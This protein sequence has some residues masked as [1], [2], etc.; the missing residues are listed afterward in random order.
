MA[1][2]E[3]DSVCTF[4]CPDACSLSV[5]VDDGRIVAV[6]GSDAVPYT[7]SV[8]CNKVARDMGD[9]VHG[10]QRL[11]HPL[12]RI[13]PKGSGQ[14]ARI[15][16]DTALDEIHQRVSDIVSRWG[17]QAVMP[18]NYAGPHGFLAGDSMSS[19]FFNRL[20]A[21]QL[22]RR[23]L[24]GG[25][26]SEAW[27]GTYGAVPGCPPEF[28]EHAKLNVVWG[29]NATVANLHLV[30]S[31]SHARRKG[32]RLVVVD[33]LRTKIAEQA[34]LHLQLLPGTDILLAWSVA[35]ELER[36]GALDDDFIAANVLGFEEFMALARA[37][38]AAR[39]AAACGLPES[40][41][42]TFAQWLAAADPLVLTPGNGLERGRNGGSGIRAAIALPAL[43]GKL[44]KGSGIVLAAGNAFPKTPAKLQRP[45]LI[46]AGTR[47]LN[48]N[49]IGRHLAED[50]LDPPLRALFI[51][52][53]NPIVVHP[54]QN[55]MRRGLA[56][57]DL[58]AVGIDVTMTESMAHCDVV[59]PAATHFEYAELYPSYGHHWL[60]R[61]E[62]VIP[63]VGESLPNTEIFRRLA[64]RFGFV[65]PCFTATDEELI[66]DA[67][68]PA[69][70]RLAGVRP[71]RISTKQALPMTGPDGRPLVLYD[72]IF[73][74]TPSGKIELKSATLAERWGAAALLPGWRPLPNPPPLAGEGRVGGPLMLIS[75]ASDKRISSTLG[76]LAGS[77]QAPPLLMNPQDAA[78]R[79]L[80]D[81]AEVR[82]WNDRGEVILRLDVTDKVPPGVVASEK[83]AWLKTSRTGQTI[84]A[85]VSADLRADLAEG[86][87]FNDTPV[88][89]TPA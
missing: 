9:F 79:N 60:Q 76:D 54:D 56:R 27:A 33:P 32:G 45:D 23:A 88:E 74:A 38:P 47:T 84:S 64:A 82:V 18:L 86:A 77:R 58:F 24:C 13:G 61:A 5:T 83:G 25:V 16:W 31:I 10:P 21:T 29:N 52:N 67:V 12:R 87:C 15:S 30:R 35:A 22:Y 42:L 81:G 51:Y 63:P 36:L 17:P 8:I 68:D 57:D 20:G 59:L 49:D 69:D 3:L 1:I 41:I 62:P 26:R 55:R 48:I 37:W 71:S 19:R 40:L 89:V 43:L 44:G 7:A 70:S 14:F 75:P 72:N 46:P 66:D 73:P 4:D 65:E 34:D 39:A 50:D 80:E 78:Q 6:R 85:L 28:A 53:H 2:A 11:R